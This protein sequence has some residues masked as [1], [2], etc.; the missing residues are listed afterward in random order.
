MDDSENIP[1]APDSPLR[2]QDP[3]FD[4]SI[5]DTLAKSFKW[6]ANIDPVLVEKNPDVPM[7]GASYDISSNLS[8]N[9]QR[10]F[11]AK[12]K[13]EANPEMN[14]RFWLTNSGER[15][16]F[17]F[18]AE[19]L[20]SAKALSLDHRPIR[21][22]NLEVPIHPLFHL[23]HWNNTPDDIYEF[24]EPAL[25]L[26]TMFLSQER[27]MRWWCIMLLGE[28]EPDMSEIANFARPA[29]RIRA[30]VPITPGNSLTAI[31]YLR[32]KGEEVVE[33]E[34]HLLSFR[35]GENLHLSRGRGPAFA[36]TSPLNTWEG[37][38]PI[39]TTWMNH[40]SEKKMHRAVVGLHGDYYRQACK[41]RD[42]KFPDENQKLRFYFLFAVNLCHEVAHTVE[43]ADLYHGGDLPYFVPEPFIGNMS[44]RE[45]GYMWEKF[46]FGGR[47]LPIN[48][49]LSCKYGLFTQAWP[50]P[51]EER[52]WQNTL[53]SIPM[54]WI[55]KIQ[56][57]EFWDDNE[58]IL[59]GET[60]Q[61]LEEFLY[62]PRT[63]GTAKAWGRGLVL[64]MLESEFLRVIQEDLEE[65]MGVQGKEAREAAVRE[66]MESAWQEMLE[67]E[68]ERDAKKEQ[69]IRA[70]QAAACQEDAHKRKKEAEERKK[71]LRRQRPIGPRNRREQ[72][73]VEVFYRIT[74][75]QPGLRVR[76][77][78][79]DL[80]GRDRSRSPPTQQ[81]TQA[82]ERAEARA[83]SVRKPRTET[84]TEERVQL[85]VAGMRK[86]WEDF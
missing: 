67:L 69:E 73:E 3:S 82:E 58:D 76:G 27:C 34:G 43:S 19:E 50:C 49:D 78:P 79:V 23:D 10:I 54:D 26:A 70:R 11:D 42:L 71:E 44:V 45:S 72:P 56:Q 14:N 60:Q 61:E 35:F 25:R 1:A 64:T 39:L 17:G 85:R 21:P 66:R 5:M 86:P 32:E 84:E 53:Y 22:N 48:D 16:H 20:I 52:D 33:G 57:Q 75:P 30:P 8:W 4:L 36:F 38:L 74:E 51:P 55:E 77:R 12:H 37:P 62:P 18:K 59:T 31:E 7:Q 63:S 13:W 29:Q 41:L 83:A 46:T 40:Y 9:P 6:R 15:V 2:G 80:L 81:K 28:R 65:E 68:E 24:L 47:I